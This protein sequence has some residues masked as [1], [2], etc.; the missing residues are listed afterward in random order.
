M[1]DMF[2]LE[3]G[4]RRPYFAV[5]TEENGVHQR[6]KSLFQSTFMN[7]IVVSKS[8]GQQASIALHL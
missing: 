5:G 2:D 8:C 1:I 6:V 7:Q 4:H 3:L